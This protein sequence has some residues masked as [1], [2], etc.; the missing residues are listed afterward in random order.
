MSD[1]SEYYK[2]FTRCSHTELYQ[3][4]R[5][6]GHNV[7]PTL[8]RDELIKVIVLDAE[9]SKAVHDI[10]ETRRAIMR[11]LIEHR[12]KLETQVTC[13]ARTFEPDACFGCVDAQVIC[14]LV[15]HGSDAQRII[16]LHKKNR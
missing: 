11:F 4:A 5:R 14:C 12:K 16:T 13:P 7:L 15:S 6:A 3:I 1:E 9:D 8:S 10:D 2:L